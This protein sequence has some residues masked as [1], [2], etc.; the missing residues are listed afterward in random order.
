[1]KII[2]ETPL[3]YFDFWEGGLDFAKNLTNQE[4]DKIEAVLEDDFPQGM[5]AEELND[6]FWF[7][8]SWLCNIIGKTEEE[9]MERNW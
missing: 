5:I 6:T 3:R 1:M 2:V 8:R 4:F 9:I 7:N